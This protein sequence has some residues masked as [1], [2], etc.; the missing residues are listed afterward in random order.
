MA[1]S[2]RITARTTSRTTQGLV[3]VVTSA[4]LFS[5]KAV[6]VKLAY[7]YGVDALSLLAL[8]M[9]F[10]LPVFAALAVLEEKRW[11]DADK[12]PSPPRDWAIVVLLGFHG[13][14]LA[15]YLD[16]LG[17]AFIP[18][19][20]E[21]LVLF[22]YPTLALLLSAIFFHQRIGRRELVALVSSY[23]GIVMAFAGEASKPGGDVLKGVL[24]IAGSA[25]AYAIYLVGSGQV[26]ERIGATRLVANGSLASCFMVLC[27]FLLTRPARSLF[28]LPPPVYAYGLCIAVFTT[29]IPTL[30]LGHGI[31]LLG[32]N[33]SA[34]AG[35]VGPVSTIVLG[36]VFLGERFGL[37]QG[38]GTLLVGAGVLQVGLRRK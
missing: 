20:L 34:I 35:M 7:P 17:L 27:H 15:S 29:V 30:L 2:V 33:L 24:Y 38:L 19:S 1:A 11:R 10:S 22:M 3:L 14:Y 9:G 12:A 32:A 23:A 21:R 37:L 6:L 8:R 13:Y 4:V 36:R 28:L 25:V 18:A 5:A 26:I 31:R 16:F